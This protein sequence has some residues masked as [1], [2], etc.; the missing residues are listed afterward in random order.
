VEPGDLVKLLGI[1]LVFGRLETTPA[2]RRQSVIVPD[3]HNRQANSFG[4]C[5]H[6]TMRGFVA[7]RFQ[8]FTIWSTTD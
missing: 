5:P 2:V 4:Y 1:G 6:R 3:L 7:R 8:C